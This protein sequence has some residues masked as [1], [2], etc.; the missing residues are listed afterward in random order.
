M[1]TVTMTRNFD[2][3]VNDQT[4][5]SYLA[6]VTY[7]KVPEAHA[8]AIRDAGAGTITDDDP[9]E[10]ESAQGKGGRAARR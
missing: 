4:N 2:H 6:G 8:A 1:K 9:A 7:N 10:S 5:I 3:H